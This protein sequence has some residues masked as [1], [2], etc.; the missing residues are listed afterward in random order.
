MTTKFRVLLVLLIVG[1]S[2]VGMSAAQAQATLPAEAEAALARGAAAVRSQQW[3]IAVRYLSEA[4]SHAPDSSGIMYNLG[5]AVDMAGGR[6]LAAL[7]WYGAYL[8]SMPEA[9]NAEQVRSRMFDL[10]IQIEVNADRLLSTAR[11]VAGEVIDSEQSAGLLAEVVRAESG[12]EISVPSSEKAG[13]YWQI[14]PAVNQLSGPQSPADL[15][16]SFAQQHSETSPVATRL[17]FVGDDGASWTETAIEPW[18]NLSPFQALV[19][20]LQGREPEEVVGAAVC[21]ASYSTNGLTVFRGI[22]SESPLTLGSEHLCFRPPA[23]IVDA[24]A[25]ERAMALLEEELS[26][27]FFDSS[28]GPRSYKESFDEETSSLV[29]WNLQL[30]EPLLRPIE[31]TLEARRRSPNGQVE[32]RSARDFTCEEG[33]PTCSIN[34]STYWGASSWSSG[35]HTVEVLLEGRVIATGGFDF[36]AIETVV[37]PDT[38]L[39]WTAK[40]NRRDVNWRNAIDYCQNLSLEGQSD[41]RLPT[42]DELEDLHEPY[43]SSVCGRRSDCGIG[44]NIFVSRPGG[45]YSVWSSERSGSD[46]AHIFMFNSLGMSFT[47]G[48]D[49]TTRVLCVRP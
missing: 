44:L 7:G 37:A 17:S 6:E 12:E 43:V 24:T 38:G 1:F 33:L 3:D 36:T 21:G 25:D 2:G 30:G 18:I 39:T 28:P 10:E 5:L 22:E 35:R 4:Q 40:D 32:T 11:Q 46:E 14:L 9:P 27:R 49:F 23:W 29:A 16:V 15:L 26:L 31:L 34:P 48:L 42:L 19:D 47:R 8:A 13:L 20:S 45:G 41:W